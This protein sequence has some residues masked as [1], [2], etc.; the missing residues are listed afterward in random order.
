L[1]SDALDFLSPILLRM[2]SENLVLKIVDF[3]KLVEP[4]ALKLTPAQLRELTVDPKKKINDE[5]EK[6]F[7]FKVFF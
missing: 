7:N 2:E 6:T 3:I 5:I 1:S 4:M